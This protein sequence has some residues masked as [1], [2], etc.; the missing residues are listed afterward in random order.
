MAPALVFDLI[1]HPPFLPTPQ[2]PER[3]LPCSLPV[4]LQHTK[5]GPASGPLHVLLPLP[6]VLVLGLLAFLIP[7]SGFLLKRPLLREA[8]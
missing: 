8:A 2:P 7:L 4:L 1:S 3:Q 6:G 5:L